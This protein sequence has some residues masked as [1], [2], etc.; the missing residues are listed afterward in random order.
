MDVSLYGIVCWNESMELSDV[1][2]Y[3]FLANLTD[4]ILV[5]R[6]CDICKFMLQIPDCQHSI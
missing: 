6:F 3:I 2:D 5:N 4:A 1:V